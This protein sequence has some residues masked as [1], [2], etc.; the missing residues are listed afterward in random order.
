MIDSAFSETEPAIEEDLPTEDEEAESE[1][2]TGNGEAPAGGDSEDG[3]RRRRRRRGRRGGR[4]GREGE[5]HRADRQTDIPG[6]GEQPAVDDATD[7]EEDSGDVQ[8][9]EVAASD[10]D[11]RGEHRERRGRGRRDRG[12]RRDRGEERKREDF[13]PPRNAPEEPSLVREADAEEVRV[14]EREEIAPV[15]REPIAVV[16]A[17]EAAE[18]AARKWQPPSPTVTEAPA[19]PKAGWWRR[20]TS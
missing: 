16:S 2:S 14:V 15:S 20:K 9:P 1:T 7:A 5:E 8:A 18:P 11:S 3:G 6:L 12:R 13:T 4:R 19:Q 10:R 17:T